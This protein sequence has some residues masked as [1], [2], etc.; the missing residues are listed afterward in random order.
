[1]PMKIS[2]SGVL[3]RAADRCE[4]AKDQPTRGLGY[5]L[6]LLLAHLEAV[7]D[8]PTRLDEFFDLWIKD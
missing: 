1:M 3:E 2:L 6:R 4:A 7:R 5:S 8:D